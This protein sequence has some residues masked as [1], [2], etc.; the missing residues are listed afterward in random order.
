MPIYATRSLV[1]DIQSKTEGLASGGEPHKTMVQGIDS[2]K[3]TI[4][5]RIEYEK[6]LQQRSRLG[7]R[8]RRAALLGVESCG[9]RRIR[10]TVGNR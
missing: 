3:L 2:A 8:R 5:G 9:D 1:R 7:A 6:A 10:N 4:F